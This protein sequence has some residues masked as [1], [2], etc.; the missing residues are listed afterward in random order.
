[1]KFD[2]NIDKIR[3]CPISEENKFNGILINVGH[4][5]VTLPNGKTS[6]RE[7]V[8]HNGAAAVVPVDEEGNVYLVIQHRIAVD[9]VTIEIP[10]GKLDSPN[11]DPFLCAK[12]ELTEETG[13]VAAQWE[14]LSHVL[15]TPGFCTETIGLY[16]ATGLTQHE[17]HLDPDEFLNLIKMPLTDAID[18]ISQ[19]KITDAKTIAGLLMAQNKLLRG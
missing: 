14:K 7:I 11:E 16:L 2:Y 15:T 13:L 8:H 1:M 17:A 4:M 3:E 12:R 5:K 18:L 9:Q 19:G 6:M 10:A